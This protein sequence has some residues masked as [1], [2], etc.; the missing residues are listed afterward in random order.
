MRPG[1]GGDENV[2]VLTPDGVKAPTES[3]DLLEPLLGTS[4]E[5]LGSAMA[6]S[7]IVLGIS[8]GSDILR[9]C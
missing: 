8:M 3:D 1:V 4:G 2:G 6:G 7:E 9:A 5:R